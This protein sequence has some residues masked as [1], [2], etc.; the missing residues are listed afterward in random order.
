MNERSETIQIL[1]LKD[2]ELVGEDQGMNIL[3][4]S[5]PRVLAHSIQWSIAW[6]SSIPRSVHHQCLFYTN[7]NTNTN[8][9]FTSF[10]QPINIVDVRNVSQIPTS[11]A[12]ICFDVKH[13]GS[14]QLYENELISNRNAIS[15][16]VIFDNSIYQPLSSCSLNETSM[17]CCQLEEGIGSI[18]RWEVCLYGVCDWME[19]GMFHKP[20]ITNIIADGTL[21]VFGGELIQING[22]NFGN[23]EE[24][25][26]VYMVDNKTVHQ[27]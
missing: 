22:L 12:T 13:A 26:R 5:L 17:V 25:L 1:L 27:Y 16:R 21:N 7:T 20:I 24:V 14:K 9:T 10:F 3:D 2:C 11:G 18:I 23:R 4:C 8:T 6:N 19:K 15:A